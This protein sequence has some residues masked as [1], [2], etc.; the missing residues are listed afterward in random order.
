MPVRMTE[1]TE[2]VLHALLSAPG[3]EAFGYEIMKASGLRAGTLYPVLAR[4]EAA[5][6]LDSYWESTG[7]AG[8]DRPRRRRYRLSDAGRE[9]ARSVLAERS[10]AIGPRPDRIPGL[11][12][13]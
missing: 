5:G 12:P 13:A 1:Q 11:Q 10:R 4:L 9:Q 8:E 2:R 7:P 3:D 6:W